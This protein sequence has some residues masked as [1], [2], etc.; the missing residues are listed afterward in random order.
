MRAIGGRDFDHGQ[1]VADRIHARAAVL[2]R[3]FDAHQAE[4]AHLPDVVER[5]LAGL[6]EIRRHRRDALLRELARDRLDLQLLFGKIEIHRD[7]SVCRDRTDGWRGNPTRHDTAAG[8]IALIY[9]FI[10]I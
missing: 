2:G 1:H 9:L 4:L 3:H 5:E 6:V 8:R 7:T 10:L